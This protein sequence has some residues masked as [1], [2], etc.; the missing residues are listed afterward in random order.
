MKMKNS[1]FRMVFV[2]YVL[3]FTFNA[4]DIRA[5]ILYLQEEQRH[6]CETMKKQL[7]GIIKDFISN[8]D[9]SIYEESFISIF[10]K[11]KENTIRCSFPFEEEDIK[12]YYF[13]GSSILSGKSAHDIRA[14]KL[15]IDLYFLNKNNAEASEYYG[16]ELI[17]RAA[18]GNIA[19]F[20]KALSS[21]SE[22]NTDSCIDNLDVIKE[23]EDIDKIKN[24]LKEM[25]DQ[26]YQE[27]IEKIMNKLPLY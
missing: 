18:V 3:L 15:L 14:M 19:N 20:V 7:R 2:S 23:K 26:E 8:G 10:S 25:K 13:L 11:I 6:D 16:F 17:P 22:T 27:I 4:Q 1:I 24:A 5:N 9:E 21:M 12:L